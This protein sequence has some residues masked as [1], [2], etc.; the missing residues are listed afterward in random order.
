MH[1]TLMRSLLRTNL[2]AGGVYID[3]LASEREK[4]LDEGRKAVTEMLGYF[5][6]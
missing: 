6:L 4:E 5:V 1:V 2:A 3:R